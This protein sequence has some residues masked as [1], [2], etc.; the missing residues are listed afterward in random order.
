M[1]N[2][3]D[4]ESEFDFLGSRGTLGVISLAVMGIC[5][6][7]V[8]TIGPAWGIDFK[9]GTELI[10]RFAET[11]DTAQVRQKFDEAGIPAEQ[12][13]QYGSP[14]DGEYLI[15]MQK[16]S[17]VGPKLKSEAGPNDI[18]AEA[19]VEQL[20][21]VQKLR[22]EDSWNWSSENPDRLDFTVPQGTE[23]DRD[24]IIEK[25][26]GLGLQDVGLNDR[27]SG[28]YALEFSGL[29]PKIDRELKNVLPDAYKPERDGMGIKR[30]ETVGPRAGEQLR[31]SGI[32]SVVV[33]LFCILV[34]V[35]FRFDLRY[36]PGAVAALVHDVVIAVGFFTFMQLEISLP[37]IAALLTIVGYSLNDTIVN[38]DRIRENLETAGTE[39]LDKLSNRSINEMLSR[40]INTSLTTLLAVVSIAVLGGGLIQN[41]AIALIVGV[42]VGTYSSVY[43]ATPVMLK[44]DEYLQQWRESREAANEP[45]V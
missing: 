36:A 32:L 11:L 24:A 33:A 26:E 16:V 45:K 27:G 28:R 43:V 42:I 34:Y 9:G 35:A 4:P 17:V 31:N 18:A 10:V 20:Q 30:I 8:L 6:A 23:I 29:K 37:I 41:F 12:V 3:V 15:Q 25:V 40:T 22:N 14:D 21:S 5:I 1:I 39:A 44:M 19:V 2:I 7:G 38:F 13:Q